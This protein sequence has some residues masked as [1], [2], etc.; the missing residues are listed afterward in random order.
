MGHGSNRKYFGNDSTS[1]GSIFDDV[2][3]YA[4]AFGQ[5]AGEDI[6]DAKKY[7]DEARPGN[8]MKKAWGG[9]KIAAHNAYER[10][11]ET[12][13]DIG[14]GTMA[15]LA[16]LGGDATS[17]F[18]LLENGVS[19]E[20]KK[21]AQYW[22]DNIEDKNS[23]GG[24]VFDEGVQWTAMGPVGKAAKYVV[25]G[26]L[27]GTKLL[28]AVGKEV[29]KKVGGKTIAAASVGGMPIAISAVDTG[30]NG[31]SV[32]FAMKNKPVIKT[33][34]QKLKDKAVKSLER[35]AMGNTAK[36]PKVITKS[37]AP[38]SRVSVSK[39]PGKTVARKKQ[40]PEDI[41]DLF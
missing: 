22:R 32:P 13:R 4:Q 41:L 14:R 3:G 10:P 34:E 30:S 8:Y 6:A 24:A 25:K 16:E 12:M 1:T 9:A 31:N 19:R 17:V 36:A 2:S 21:S 5:I 35:K 20:A 27:G 29:A 37:V 18:G 40:I 7:F 11:G 26:G 39:G 15:G 38:G 23:I 28:G 33:E